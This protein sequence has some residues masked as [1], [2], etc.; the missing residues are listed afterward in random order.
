MSRATVNVRI[1][2][3]AAAMLAALLIQGP[4]TAGAAVGCSFVGGTVTVMVSPPT[5]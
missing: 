3:L 5:S 4:P 1:P 2:T